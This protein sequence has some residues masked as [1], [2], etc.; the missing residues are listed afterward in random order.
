MSKNK[1]GIIFTN[2]GRNIAFLAF[3][4][5]PFIAIGW[6]KTREKK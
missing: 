3:Y 4:C 2:N 5:L 6:W 1:M